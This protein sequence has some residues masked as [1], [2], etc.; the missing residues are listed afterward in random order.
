MMRIAIVGAGIAGAYLSALLVSQGYQVDVYEESK[1]LGCFCAWGTVESEL[2]DFLKK[3]GLDYKDYVFT[4]IRRIILGGFEFKVSNLI[5]FNKPKLIYDLLKN[6][7]VKY[8]RAN[9][10]L[11]ERYDLV[12]D[13]TGWKRS[14]LP[15][16]TKDF[17]MPTIEY[18]IKTDKLNEN[19]IYIV[20]GKVGYAWMFPMT[21]NFWHIGAGDAV[22]NP[23][24]LTFK[25]MKKYNVDFKSTC[26]CESRIRLLPPEYCRPIVYKNIV[27][28]GESIGT[29]FP[30]TGEGTA[31]SMKCALMFYEHLVNNEIN[32]FEKT[33]IKEFKWYTA[34]YKLVKSLTK[35][36]IR[37]FLSLLRS[38]PG[39]SRYAER[40]GAKTI[41]NIVK[42]FIKI[43]EYGGK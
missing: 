15:P 5:T 25:I 23:Y 20:P 4:R 30:I 2:R 14:I 42:V 34:I 36:K 21:N 39:F 24:E 12:V 17:T 11:S 33:I 18:V 28:C 16:L 7:N 1:R 27:G 6:V 9:A 10:E 13:A 22:L 37:L 29:V 40:L 19:T 3:I 32:K 31:P 26:F 35:S 41:G 43:M 38:I 8:L